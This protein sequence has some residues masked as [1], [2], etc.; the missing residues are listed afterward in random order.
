[1]KIVIIGAGEVGFHLAKGLSEEN[2]DITLIDIALEK[3]QRASETLDVIVVHGDGASPRVL[4]EADVQNAD[5]VV[6]VTRVDEVN[7][8]ASQLAHQLG[9]PKII[10]RLRNTE[11]TGR[12]S[13]LH[14]EKFGIE[15]VIH[16]ELAATR[17]II[18]LVMQT[19]A[20]SV[21][22]F[23]GGRLQLMGIRLDNGC[24][25][26]GKDLGEIRREHSDFHFS[27]VAV[28]R[29]RDTVIPHGE[30]RFELNDICYFL[31]TKERVPDLLGMMGKPYQETRKAMIL[32]GGKIGRALAR[33]LQDKIDVRLVEGDREKAQR[34]ASE[35]EKTLILSGDGTDI[36][37]LRSENVEE[38]DSFIAVTQ[39]EQTNLLS[40]LLVK[41]LGARQVLVHVATA[42]YI[43][44]LKLMG[45]DG[46]ISKNMCTVMAILETIKS[47]RHVVITDFEDIDVEALEFSPSP[48]SRVTR[49]VLSHIKFPE[50]CIV[51]A[52][53]HHG[54]VFIPTG[55]TQ[56]SEEDTVLVFALPQSI[57]RVEKL[58]S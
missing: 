15:K 33:S 28:M 26:I 24:P 21:V 31:V 48:G 50:N 30:T 13:I 45:I 32:G 20:S 40:G 34:L 17:E 36:E 16:P 53:N 22:E 6:A 8:I 18:R 57:P 7:L 52:V 4:R 39:N 23:E 43:P 29:G 1:M 58:F 46:V 42:E 2:Y 3:V 35:L 19:A 5:I 54:H 51:G 49:E 37:F 56:I 10:A 14:P 55:D 11:Y 47:D 9:A 44:I 12:D 27:A 38:L 41:H 25:V